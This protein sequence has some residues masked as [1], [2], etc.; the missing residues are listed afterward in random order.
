MDAEP[1]LLVSTLNIVLGQRLVRRLCEEKEEYTLSATE[2]KTLEKD[3]D[4]GKVLAILKEENIVADNATWHTI[5]VYR[6]KESGECAD[7]Y[8]GRIGIHEILPISPTIKKLIMDGATSA[9][10]EK[11]A[12]A[13]GMLT[14]IEDGMF[15]VAQG[16]TTIEEVL[17]VVNE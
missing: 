10:I 13:D 1:F 15:K 14:M 9:E 16:V 6:P 4:L 8:R 12:R 17:R 2:I 3:V 5:P 11:Q 7:G